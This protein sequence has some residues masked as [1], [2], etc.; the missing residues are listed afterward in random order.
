MQTRELGTAITRDA[1]FAGSEDLDKIE[2]MS[3]AVHRDFRQVLLCVLVATISAV[4]VAFEYKSWKSSEQ[5][6]LS[7]LRCFNTV[8]DFS[9]VDQD[10]KTVAEVDLK[11]KVWV[12]DFIFTRCLGPCPM[13]NSWYAELDR[14]FQ[15]SGQLKLI[16]FT[17]D[18]EFD[19]SAVLKRYAAKYE[20]SSR[21]HFLTG[22][23]DKLYE[24]AIKGF[25]LATQGP[26]SVTP[27]FVHSTKFTLVDADG[28]IRGY[29]DGMSSEVVQKLLTDIGSLLRRGGR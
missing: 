15:K 14:N 24:L 27:D 23:K 8:P 2:A 28:V 11:G 9:F 18:P 10:G 17:V 16:S 25:Q 21:W 19:T 7:A 22:E 26:K 20:A 1:N 4:I 12:A 3:F 5:K 13:M 29:Y 6:G